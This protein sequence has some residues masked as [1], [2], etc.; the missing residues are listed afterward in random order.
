L[1]LCGENC[2]YEWTVNSMW[3]LATVMNKP[4]RR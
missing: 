2:I 4:A 3:Y 1:R